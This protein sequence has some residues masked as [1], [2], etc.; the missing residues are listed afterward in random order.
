MA[1]WEQLLIGVL[2]ALLL[3]WFRPGIR[4]ALK[5]SRDAERRDWSGALLPIGLVVLFVLLLIGLVR[6]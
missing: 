6:G 3:L 4:A 1:L 2:V 5:Q